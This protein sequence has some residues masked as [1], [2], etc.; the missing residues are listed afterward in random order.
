MLSSR[1]NQILTTNMP[2]N[3]S[4]FRSIYYSH[5]KPNNCHVFITIG[6]NAILLNINLF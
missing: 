2:N 5:I 1:S 4:L 3:K 6:M